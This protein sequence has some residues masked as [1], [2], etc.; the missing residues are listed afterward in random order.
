MN[1][2]NLTLFLCL[3]LFS[4]KKTNQAWSITFDGITSASSPQAIDLND[5]GI[6]DIII[7]AGGLEWDK[8][9]SG[10]LAINGADGELLW[11]AKARNQIVGSAVFLDINSDEIPD[12]IIGGRSAELQAI[13]GKNGELIWEFY[14]RKEKMA[15]SYEGWF[16]FFNPQFVPDQDQDGI[17]DILICN[18]GNALLPAGY[19]DRPAGKLLIISS[20]TGKVITEDFMPDGRETYFSTVCIDCETSKNPTIIFG[21]GGET[22]AGH[23]YLCKLSDLLNKNLKSSI[24]LDSSSKKGYIAP[25]I[26]ADFNV[27]G[28]LDILVNVAEGKTKLFDG[29]TLKPL[30]SVSCDSSEVFS[31]PAI[32]YFTGNDKTL[33][34]FVNFAKGIYP[35]YAHTEQ[36]L[37]D[38]KTGN[39]IKKYHERRFT[40]ASPLSADLN[41]D[42]VDEVIMNTAKDSLIKNRDKPF[43][44][45]T[46]FDFK[47]NSVDFLAK[48]FNGACFA[49]TPWLGDLDNDTQLDIIYS[50]S[51]AIISEFPGMTTY[52][53]PPLTLTI[54][55]IEIDK[56]PSKNVKWGSYMN[57]GKSIY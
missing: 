2:K 36:W 41:Q 56:I 47:H 12:V 54:H 25:P 45:L 14:K 29:K 37:I 34:V 3:L 15:S 19:K 18:G 28:T 57:G 11:Q 43:Y 8:T 22:Q 6:K 55:R 27:D 16:N 24:V 31:Q 13:N 48:R 7:G 50:G 4:C 49:S 46:V 44:Q 39:V 26:L 52:Q 30:W 40:Y 20:L 23:L 1:S 38:G 10:I 51:P 17:K 33:D 35:I 21:S 53:K 5:D 32:G 9:E 42:G